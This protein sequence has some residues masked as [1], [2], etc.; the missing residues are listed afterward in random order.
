MM[1]WVEEGQ[2]RKWFALASPLHMD[3]YVMTHAISKHLVRNNSKPICEA[4]DSL[5]RVHVE[6]H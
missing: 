6:V 1:I 5:L 3:S 2:C 4:L